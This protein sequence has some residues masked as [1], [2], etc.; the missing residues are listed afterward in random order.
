MSINYPN[1]DPVA[2][3]LGPINIYWY[4][5]AYIIG[6][7]FGFFY[8]NF[9][10]KKYKLNLPKNFTDDLLTYIVLGIIIGG[11]LGYV[12]F[13]DLTNYLADPIKILKTWTGGM[14]FHGAV[15]GLAIAVYL[16]SRKLKVN[17][18]LIGDLIAI[19]VP[20]GIFLGRIA[21]FIN[22][23]LYG[24]VSN[25]AW[26]M[27]FPG[28]DGTAR[29]PSQ[30]YEA[31]FEGLVLL[32][33]L[34]IIVIIT[35]FKYHKGLYLGLFLLF[36][37][38]IRSILENFREPTDNIGYILNYLTMGQLLSFPLII[39]GCYLLFRKSN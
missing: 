25:V 13:Y 24:R 29:H 28:T 8:I 15:I 1:I 18:L 38:I 20:F 3:Y 22:G 36:Y 39:I 12:I 2:I 33:T 21:N 19:S 9:L 23:E 14:S 17:I 34:N 31:L 7:L 16:A 27:I 4:S 35:K 5:I 26:A 10:N 32:I 30:L 6:I 11:R 37:G